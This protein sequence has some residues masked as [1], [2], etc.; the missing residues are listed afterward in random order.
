MGFSHKQK[1]QLVRMI[2]GQPEVNNS[3][4]EFT[5]GF[6]ESDLDNVAVCHFKVE[7]RNVYS[8]GNTAYIVRGCPL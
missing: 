5:Q 7:A 4:L 1:V 2:L 6:S 8:E 3:T